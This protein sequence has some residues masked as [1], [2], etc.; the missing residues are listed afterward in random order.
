MKILK[1]TD[2]SPQMAS[3]PPS[4]R[5]SGP[6]TA[7]PAA[8]SI[9]LKINVIVMDCLRTLLAFAVSLAPRKCETIT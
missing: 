6:L 2:A 5:G 7:S 4:H 9:K 1:Y 8:I 3:S